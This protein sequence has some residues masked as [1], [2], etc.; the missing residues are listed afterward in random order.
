MFVCHVCAASFP[1]DGFCAHDGSPLRA[2]AA[3]PLIGSLIG[4]YRIEKL[5]GVGGMG[6]VYKAVHPKIGSRVAVKVLAHGPSVN[7]GLIARFF[8]EARAVNVIRHEN[9]VNILDLDYLPDRRPYIVMEFLDGAPLSSVIADDGPLPIGTLLRIVEDV[10][11]ALGAAHAESIVHRDLKPD[12]IFI[13]PKGRPKVLDFGIAKLAFDQ[14]SKK[15]QTKEGSLLGTPHYMSPEQALGQTVDTRSDI[16]SMGVILYECVTGEPPFESE[17]LFS[18]LKQHVNDTPASPRSRRPEISE[19]L[20]SII[21]RALEKDPEKRWPTVSEL[22]FAL[23]QEQHGLP[24]QAWAPLGLSGESSSAANRPSQPPSGAGRLSHAMP[25]VVNSPAVTDAK[26][27]TGSRKTMTLLAFFAV[28]SIASVVVLSRMDNATEEQVES[29]A[30]SIDESAT[31]TLSAAASQIEDAGTKVAVAAVD[32]ATAIGGASPADAGVAGALPP[33]VQFVPPTPNPVTTKPGAI[34]TRDVTPTRSPSSFDMS[35]YLP[36]ALARARKAFPDAVLIRVDAQGVLPNGNANLTLS[37]SFDV[38]YRF[39]SPSRAQRPADLPLGMDH[40]PTC[41][42]Y[43]NVTSKGTNNY[44]LVGWKC[45]TEP[46]KR[47]H[48]SAKELWQRAIAD[49]APKTNAVAEISHYGGQ[50]WFDIKGTYS[51]RFKDDC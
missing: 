31:E 26:T 15:G 35:G 22:N 17:A 2:A 6:Q 7:E 13:S 25:S 1:E 19:G 10:L 44:P 9:I 23:Q 37:D 43:V 5:I 41:L 50:W 45:D 32:A 51:K 30:A 14:T 12:N 27:Q 48:C 47:L 8:D 42:F 4:P 28:A 29:T 33:K 20:E 40:K 34:P 36:K 24:G 3:D 49:G 16:Y 46:I 18:L 38:T 39:I 21:M 11:S